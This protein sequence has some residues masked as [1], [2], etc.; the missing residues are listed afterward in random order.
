MY[1]QRG[2]VPDGA[3]TLA[4][5]TAQSIAVALKHLPAKP[6]LLAITGG[7][8]RNATLMWLI[9]QATKCKVIKVEDKKLNGDALEAEAFA[10]LAARVLEKLP[11]SFPATTG[12]KKPY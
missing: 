7:G 9:A 11:I 10:Y 3:M 1:V 2:V 12:R 5:M 6:K 4:A 8:R